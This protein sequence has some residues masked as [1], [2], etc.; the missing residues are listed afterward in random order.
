MGYAMN[1]YSNRDGVA[2][3][4]DRS[5]LSILETPGTPTY[6]SNKENLITA[7]NLH[8]SSPS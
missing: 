1:K 7:T 3:F 2:S 5:S 4:A 8:D 6:K